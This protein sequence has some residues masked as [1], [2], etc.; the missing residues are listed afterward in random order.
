MH[1]GAQS[2]PPPPPTTTTSIQ[3]ILNTQ[4]GMTVVISALM[5][6]A[7]YTLSPKIQL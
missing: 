1:A 6:Q 3:D 7:Y 5:W 2:L 4:A